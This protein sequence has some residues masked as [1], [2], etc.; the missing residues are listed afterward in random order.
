MS[1]ELVISKCGNDKGRYFF[2]VSEEDG[3]LYLADGKKR[4]LEKPKKKKES[5][6][7]MAGKFPDFV[8]FR[9]NTKK[10]E[11]VA[12][13]RVLNGKLKE[14]TQKLREAAQQDK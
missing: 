5:H 11:T 14:Y 7:E 4:T 6:V 1:G 10:F 12:R 8:Y 9:E 13:N 3:F 2:V